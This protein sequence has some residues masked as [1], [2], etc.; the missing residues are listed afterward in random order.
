[1][2]GPFFYLHATYSGLIILL[3]FASLMHGARRMIYD[4]QRMI[5]IDRYINLGDVS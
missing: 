4:F 5:D 1:M 2:L 3:G